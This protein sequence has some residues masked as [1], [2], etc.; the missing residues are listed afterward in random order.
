MPQSLL[1]F[2]ANEE[3]VQ[4]VETG[5]TWNMRMGLATSGELEGTKLTAL[6]AIVTFRSAWKRFHPHSMVWLPTDDR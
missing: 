4:D 2:D 1:T 6:P 5:S 3:S